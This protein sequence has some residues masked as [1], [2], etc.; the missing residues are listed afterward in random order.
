MRRELDRHFAERFFD[1]MPYL[2]GELTAVGAEEERALIE[3]GAIQA[4]G[5][6]YVGEQQASFAR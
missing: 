4:M 5:F 3:A 6:R 1:W 2:Y